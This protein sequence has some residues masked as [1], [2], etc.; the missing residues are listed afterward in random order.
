MN[1]LALIAL[2]G[3]AGSVLRFILSG[4]TQR[5]TQ[6]SFPFGTLLVNALGCFCIGVCAA[7]F[8]GGTQ[9]KEEY[10]L[11]IMVGVLGGFTT[12]SS[13]SLESLKLLQEGEYLK[14]AAYI[15]ASNLF[16]LAL[17][18]YGYRSAS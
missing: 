5:T 10:R 12:F 1:N 16:C 6:S 3:A 17:V 2:G 18:W 13:Y 4:W 9:L 8:F 11:G 7:L 14:A 15:I